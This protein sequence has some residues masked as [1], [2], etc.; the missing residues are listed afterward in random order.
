MDE[1]FYIKLIYK[2]LKNEISTEEL[3][4]LKVWTNTSNEN[5]MLRE[6]IELSWQLG[7]EEEAFDID[8]DSDL[9]KVKSQMNN[10]SDGNRTEKGK[11]VSLLGR[12]IAIAASFLFLLTASYS[13]F[14]NGGKESSQLISSNTKVQ[15][16]DLKDG[17]KVYLNKNSELEIASDFGKGN[18]KLKLKGEAFFEVAKNEALPFEVTCAESVVTVLGTSFNIKEQTDKLSVIVNTGK[19]RLSGDGQQMELVK[20]EIGVHNYNANSI[21]KEKTTSAN[22]SSWQSNKVKF[23][24]KPLSEILNELEILY[25][26]QFE[27]ANSE[28]MDCKLTLLIYSN[29]LSDVL[30]E[31]C[32]N[33]DMNQENVNAQ[34]I[35]LSNGSC[36]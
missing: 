32:D 27:V 16:I 21:T 26:V 9:Q 3:E 14:L 23:S 22:A 8:V 25:D 34:T 5:A 33:L 36:Q 18:R 10:A 12:R 6:E 17:S 2:A 19:V 28:V 4:T 20:N 13:I 35:R 30:K 31:I 24:Q 15:V 1:D 11:V 7:A 29:Q